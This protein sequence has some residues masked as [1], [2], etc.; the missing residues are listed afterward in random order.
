M[1]INAMAYVWKLTLE[2]VAKFILLSYADHADN[3]GGNIYPAVSTIAKKTCLSSRTVIRTTH[4]LEDIGLLL[5]DGHGPNNTNRWKINMDWGGLTACQSDSMSVSHSQT[6]TESVNPLITTTIKSINDSVVIKGLGDT[7][8]DVT[9]SDSDILSPAEADNL[10]TMAEFGISKNKLTV[11]LAGRDYMTPGYIRAHGQDLKQ[12]KNGDYRP[13]LLVD[14]L[15]S[16]TPAPETRVNGHILSCDC[17]ECAQLKYL[18]GEFAEFIE[19]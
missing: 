1:S 2:P 8:S 9:E 10:A 17:E 18:E 5:A 13:G 3:D 6:D 11:K 4:W 15:K 16:H 7:Q 12:R 14:L 19:H